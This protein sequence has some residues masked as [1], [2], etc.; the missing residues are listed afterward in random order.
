MDTINKSMT[1]PKDFPVFYATRIEPRLKGLENQR[2]KIVLRR[3]I[4][5]AIFLVIIAFIPVAFFINPTAGR[6]LMIMTAITGSVAFVTGSVMGVRLKNKV[7]LIMLPELAQIVGLKLGSRRE[8]SFSLDMFQSIGILPVGNQQSMGDQFYG[9]KD[10]IRIDIADAL[11][12]QKT[13]QRSN[14]K[15][16]TST[17]TLFQ[18]PLFRLTFN[19]PLKSQ[20]TLVKDFGRLINFMSQ[21]KIPGEPIRLEDIEFEN[22]FEAYGSDQVEAR[23]ILT[24]YFMQRVLALSDHSQNLPLAI[25][26]TPG[27][28]YLALNDSVDWF[29]AG[30][31]STELIDQKRATRLLHQLTFA[32]KI[33]E[34]LDLSKETKA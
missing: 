1:D 16:T 15:T 29:E 32:F 31:L 21:R 2:Q 25:A 10:G 8:K 22:R 5:L 12:Q 7:K 14:G 13:K 3:R 34:I 18:G 27:F 6:F 24:P 9:E 19:R 26:F 20:V 33:A 4:M 28:V 30:S 11:I 23:Y 17:T